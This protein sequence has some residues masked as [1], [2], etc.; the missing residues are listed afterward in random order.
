MREGHGCSIIALSPSCHLSR[1]GEDYLKDSRASRTCIFCDGTPVTKE[2]VVPRWVSNALNDDTRFQGSPPP[3]IHKRRVGSGR[4][5]EWGGEDINV[6]AKCVCRICNNG[7]MA[8]IEGRAQRML[9]P[10]IM[11]RA[12]SLDAEDQA[13]VAAWVAL[14]ALLFRYT[15]EP[16]VSPE[17]DWLQNFRDHQLPPSTCYQWLAAYQGDKTFHYAGHTLDVRRYPDKP[18]RPD[19]E[20]PNGID[21]TFV[22]GHLIANIIWIRIGKPGNLDPPGFVRIWPTTDMPGSWPPSV[23]FNDAGVD[24]ITGRFLSK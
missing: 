7:W 19:W 15:E 10:M 2:H 1:A 17:Q 3:V 4:I 21:V 14:H 9:K 24:G 22:I 11:G 5:H 18:R 8:N 6:S 20:T 16:F 12:V 23:I 13:A